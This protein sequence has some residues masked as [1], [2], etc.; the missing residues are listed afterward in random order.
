MLLDQDHI[1]SDDRHDGDRTGVGH[2]DPFDR[3]AFRREDGGSIESEERLFSDR[4]RTY[5][6][7]G[8]HVI[9]SLTPALRRPSAR[10]PSEICDVRERQR[11]NP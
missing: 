3:M 7:E 10:P 4:P 8:I 6:P 5:S 11:R 9:D 1:V 2:D